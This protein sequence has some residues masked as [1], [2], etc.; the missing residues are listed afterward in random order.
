MKCCCESQTVLYWKI[1]SRKRR[2]RL[3]RIEHDKSS[4]LPAWLLLWC[5]LLKSPVVAVLITQCRK[6]DRKPSVVGGLR[7]RHSRR[8]SQNSRWVGSVWSSSGVR[9]SQRSGA[10]V[11]WS[12][13]GVR[14][15]SGKPRYKCW[16]W[17]SKASDS[18][19]TLVDWFPLVYFHHLF[20]Y[21]FAQWSCI[22]V[23]VAQNVV[24]N[25]DIHTNWHCR[26]QRQRSKW[27][28]NCTTIW[29]IWKISEACHH[30]MVRW[31]GSLWNTLC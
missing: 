17:R 18:S 12:S 15:P 2:G 31:R 6:S 22:H 13:I 11:S 19:E 23:K 28:T 4:R 7:R 10:Q 3:Q 1:V 8:S 16:A 30:M 5:P 9:G 24:H 14:Q 21:G 25:D 20:L 27:S 29:V 26:I